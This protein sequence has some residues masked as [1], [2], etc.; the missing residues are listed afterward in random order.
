M[1]KK[2]LNQKVIQIICLILIR[3]LNNLKHKYFFVRKKKI[4][5]LKIRIK[6]K[7]K[8]YNYNLLII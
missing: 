8:N 2:Y 3:L 5:V 4:N 1:F 7:N 6:F